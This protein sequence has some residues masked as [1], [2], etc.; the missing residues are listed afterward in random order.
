M[1][2][3]GRGKLLEILLNQ[4]KDAGSAATASESPEETLTSGQTGDDGAKPDFATTDGDDSL[5]NRPKGRGSLWEKVVQPM[6][7]LSLDAGAKKAA[8]AATEEES[9]SVST[10]PD[11]SQHY[12]TKGNPK[13]IRINSGC[14]YSVWHCT[15]ICFVCRQAFESGMQLLAPHH[16]R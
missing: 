4:Y 5:A 11:T 9:T 15:D 16:K 2:C 6:A 3:S 10:Q 13:A 8:A 1:S 12:G 7:N 14:S